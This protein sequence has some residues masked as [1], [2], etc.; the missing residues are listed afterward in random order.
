[1]RPLTFCDVATFYCR[2]GGGIRTYYDAKLE[3][4]RR[5]HRHR[6]VLIIPGKRSS[7]RALTPSVTLVETRG[8]G[9][10]RSH[11]GYRLFL[12]FTHIRS[13]VRECRPDVLESGD[14]WISGPLALW[15]RRQDGTARTVSSFFHSDPIST[16]VEPAVSRRV[17]RWMAHPVSHVSSRAFYTLQA[18]YDITM[19]SS[20]VSVDRLA[21]EGVTNVWCTPFGVDS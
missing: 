7:R 6:Y 8:I 9:V 12:D 10:T 4:F 16:Y 3:W 19:V 14:P 2:T 1:M 5:Q 18:S 20:T 15:L 13:M 17:P 21:Q 11:E